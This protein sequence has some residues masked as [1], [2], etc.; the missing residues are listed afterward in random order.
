MKFR[1]YI[2]S[3]RGLLQKGECKRFVLGNS[4]ADYD[5]VVGALI[6]AFYLTRDEGILYLP[7]VDCPEADLPLRFEQVKVF[8][9]FNVPMDELL[10]T[11]MV[12]NLWTSGY[13]FVL[14]DHN[15]RTTIAPENLYEVIDHHAFD[16]EKVKCNHIINHVGS[17]LTL[18]YFVFYPELLEK[19][20][21]TELHGKFMKYLEHHK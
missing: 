20:K 7:L 13:K 14:Y 4:G 9:A 2:K 11:S 8:S 3:L 15:N 1:E 12:P 18:L 16:P 10:F 19:F 6:Y 5:S 17:A 21:D